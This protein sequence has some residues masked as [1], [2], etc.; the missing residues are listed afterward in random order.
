MQ[1]TLLREAGSFHNLM[2]YALWARSRI[3][4][5]YAFD[6]YCERAYKAKREE[7]NGI[8]LW[9]SELLRDNLIPTFLS[10]SYANLLNLFSKSL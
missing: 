2:A 4:T 7:P 8:R 5:A 3:L 10:C 1:Y 9:Q 6:G